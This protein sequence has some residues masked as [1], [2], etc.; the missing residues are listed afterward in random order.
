MHRA[1]TSSTVWQW[2]KVGAANVQWDISFASV[3]FCLLCHVYPSFERS[4]VREWESERE[5][6][7]SCKWIWFNHANLSTDSLVPFTFCLFLL[8]LSLTLSLSL[9]VGK[10]R[11]VLLSVSTPLQVRSLFSCC[12]AAENYSFNTQSAFVEER[13]CVC[14]CVQ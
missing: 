4:W 3:S 6:E 9:T 11:P 10:L 1:F 7:R 14:L 8:P 2:M 5:R 13:E 12:T